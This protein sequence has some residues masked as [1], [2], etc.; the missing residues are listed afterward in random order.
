MSHASSRA[1]LAAPILVLALGVAFA[2]LVQSAVL[3]DAAV[4]FFY[5]LLLSGSW[6]LLAGYSGQMS[7]A[8]VA[9]SVG[10][11]YG[12][13]ALAANA[14]L[15]VF[16]SIPLAALGT[17]LAGLVI[18]AI[19][20]RFREIT[21]A[22]ATFAFAGVFT[23]W[24]TGATEW[25]GG[26]N[27][28]AVDPLFEGNQTRAFVW[29]G[30]GLAALFFLLQRL[31]L[32]SRWGILMR[33]VRDREDVARGLG[34]RT[35]AIKVA[36]FAYTAFWAGLAG[37]FYATYVEFITPSIG[38]LTNMGLVVAMAVVGGMGTAAG[39]LLGT[40][41]FRVIDYYTRG[42]GGEFTVLI[43]AVILLFMML[44]MR[45]GLVGL[46]ERLFRR[47]GGRRDRWSD[48]AGKAA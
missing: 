46:L 15:P 34:A 26:S 5:F 16:L 48:P 28:M 21:F 18:G 22:L 9:F 45:D 6:N 8:H 38:Q 13:A 17:A 36:V 29:L 4:F 43:F 27:G 23:S 47:F 7:F 12:T 14:G 10:G 1:R 33:A 2:T 25:T 35:T 39:P 19:T 24:L 11:A 31:I 42:Y 3:L 37:G 44:F 41:L 32:A 30:L 40:L 20:L